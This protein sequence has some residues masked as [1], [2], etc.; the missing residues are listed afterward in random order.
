MKTSVD[1]DCFADSYDEALDEALTASGEDRQYFSKGRV[2][3][4]A[5]CLR[6]MSRKPHR[7]MDFGCGTGVTTPLLARMLE[8]ETIIGVD[9]SLRSLEVARKNHE[10]NQIGFLP[11][12][13][14]VPTAD[15][16]LAYCNGVFHH[17]PQAQRARA[18]RF[19]YQSLRTGGLF[20]FWENNPWNPGTRYVMARCAFDRDA[21]TLTPVEA[22]RLLRSAGFTVLRTNF[23]F[24]FP[25][26]LKALRSVERLV[27]RLPLG[28]QYHVLCQKSIR[29]E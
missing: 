21:V 10:S 16:D 20:S 7:L 9:T 15:V 6:R 29:S 28:A 5:K 4:L 25:R 22:R 26:V 12:S 13:E 17:I 27:S 1:F 8:A 11:V 23:H 19:L 24:I 14:Y 3:S 2:K 18:L